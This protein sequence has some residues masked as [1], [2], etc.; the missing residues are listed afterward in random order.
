MIGK[1]A[2]SD[3]AGGTSVFQL[4]CHVEARRGTERHLG[5]LK[6]EGHVLWP[7]P[8][9]TFSHGRNYNPQATKDR[10]GRNPAKIFQKDSTGEGDQGCGRIFIGGH[11]VAQL[12]QF[13]AKGTSGTTLGVELSA[14]EPA[15]H[16]PEMSCPSLAIAVIRSFPMV[17]SFSL[18]QTCF[19]RRYL[20]EFF[21]GP[22]LTL[23]CR[24]T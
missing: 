12:K 17:I 9:L 24:W 4:A 14:V 7:R 20:I 21:C 11:S 3:G 5:D 23:V 10:S 16:A 19:Y 22:F 13:F 8:P 1:S 15:W 6:A 18:T 2:P